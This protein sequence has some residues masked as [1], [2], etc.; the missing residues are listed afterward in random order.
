MPPKPDCCVVWGNRSPSWAPRS[1]GL[2]TSDY[3]DG[4]GSLGTVKG[5]TENHSVLTPQRW[6]GW[7]FK[8]REQPPLLSANEMTPTHVTLNE[9]DASESIT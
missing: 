1:R 7:G 3:S 5:L 4:D 8:N 2:V 6:E 9:S